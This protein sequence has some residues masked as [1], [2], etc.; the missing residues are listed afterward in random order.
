MKTLGQ[1]LQEFVDYTGM[2]PKHIEEQIGM[3]N[4]SLAKAIKS[5]KTLSSRTLSLIKQHYPEVSITYLVDGAGN[6]IVGNVK[7]PATE[8]EKKLLKLQEEYFELSRKYISLLE[9]MQGSQPA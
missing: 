3:S 8:C 9:K 4:G 5:G 2:K 1:R 6:L 7:Q